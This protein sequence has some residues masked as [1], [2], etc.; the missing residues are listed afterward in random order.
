M[1]PKAAVNAAV[2]IVNQYGCLV[3][4]VKIWHRSRGKDLEKKASFET[5]IEDNTW[6]LGK[7]FIK[8]YKDT[9][10]LLAQHGS[11]LLHGIC[12]WCGLSH[13][14]QMP[15][16]KCAMSSKSILKALALTVELEATDS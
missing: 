12:I 2:T 9:T 1:R 3:W 15:C 13:Q 4:M 10:K 7:G 14:M 8:N 6:F 5:R 11:R 16:V